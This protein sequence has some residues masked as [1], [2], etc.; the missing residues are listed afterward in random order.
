VATLGVVSRKIRKQ[1]DVKQ[2]VYFA[3]LE[4]NKI[5]KAIRNHKVEF[6]ELPKYPAVRRDLSL[7]LDE[8]ITFNELKMEALK[9]EK[10]LLKQVS[11]FDVYEGENLGSGKKSYAMSFVLRDDSK[12]LNDKQIDKIMTAII[13]LFEQKFGATIR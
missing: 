8:K 13:R 3:E 4:W 1:F 7:L 9:L 6:V 10:K 12:T 2:E 5:L 11:L